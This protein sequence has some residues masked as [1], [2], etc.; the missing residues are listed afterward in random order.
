MRNGRD[1][2]HLSD[3]EPPHGSLG[4]KALLDEVREQQL[5][6]GETGSTLDRHIPSE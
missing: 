1:D 2:Q 4:L 3:V 5:D 6:H